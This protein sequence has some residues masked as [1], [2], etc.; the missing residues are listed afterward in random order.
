MN[1]TYT[2]LFRSPYSVP[3]AVQVTDE[4]LWIVD[5]ITDRAALVRLENPSEYYGVPWM[6]R[7]IPSESSNTSGMTI[8]DGSL[9]LAANGDAGIW[10]TARPTD[11]GPHT[12]EILRVDPATGATQARYPIPGGGGTHGT[13]YDQFE[14]GYLWVEALGNAKLHK[15]RISD[16]SIQ[17][18][19]ELPYPRA[20]GLVQ[21]ADGMWV[22]FTGHRLILKL[23]M[24]GRELARITV[25]D[26]EPEPHCLS[27]YGDDLL[28]CD[29]SSGW[30]VKIG[31]S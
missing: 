26:S 17:H 21:Q 13:E 28:Y 11:A 29:A 16:W 8:G 7:E 5:Q 22:V 19:I 25:P 23:A 4:G 27:A 18:T 6:I 3:N 31:M 24:D 30:I 15:M 10:R 2:K 12:G 1:V 20:H 9:W 14:P